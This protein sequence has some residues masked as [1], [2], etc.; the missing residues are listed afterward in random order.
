MRLGAALAAVAELGG[1]EHSGPAARGDRL[2]GARADHD[3][4]CLLLS[5][6]P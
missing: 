4:A 1:G 3:G 2:H 5:Y 6:V